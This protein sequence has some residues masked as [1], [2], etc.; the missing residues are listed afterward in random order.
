M[1]I[2]NPESS[3]W[4]VVERNWY[5]RLV[6]EINTTVIAQ[7]NDVTSHRVTSVIN[8]NVIFLFI[9]LLL[10]SGCLL[11]TSLW[12]YCDCCFFN[13]SPSDSHVTLIWKLHVKWSWQLICDSLQMISKWNYF[14][15][16]NK[17]M[18][19]VSSQ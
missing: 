10:L 9:S 13:E 6:W 18:V 14:L 3:L 11:M 16:C 8:Q 5:K 1:L 17:A 2:F 12:R 7:S 4:R 19:I 15:C